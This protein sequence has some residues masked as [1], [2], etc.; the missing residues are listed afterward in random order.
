MRPPDRNNSRPLTSSPDRPPRSRRGWAEPAV[1][2]PRPVSPKGS[3]F[4]Q[5]LAAVLWLAPRPQRLGVPHGLRV[6]PRVGAVPALGAPAAPIPPRHRGAPRRAAPTAP[7]TTS[8]VPPRAAGSAEAASPRG[9]S[10]SC[11]PA[12]R[13]PPPAASRAGGRRA[14]G[15][16]TSPT[17]PRAPP[18]RQ[19]RR[20]R[21]RAAPSVRTAQ[22]E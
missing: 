2:P 18:G 6:P 5:G 9:A 10:G 20:R 12:G 19:W 15:G 8:P 1:P 4:P 13:K 7:R 21:L 22:S 3:V 16:T 17:P 14:R 11:S